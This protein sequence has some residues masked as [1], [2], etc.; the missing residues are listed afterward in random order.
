[1]RTIVATRV[2]Q[3]GPPRGS[4]N[5]EERLMVRFPRVW[6]AVA[7][8]GQRLFSPRSRLRRAFFRREMISAYAA[9]S[10]EDYELI[11]VRYAPGIEFRFA[12]EFG[13]LDVGGTSAGRDGMLKLINAF[14]EAWQ[15][16][17]FHPAMF[18][19]V[20]DRALALGH[21]RQ[22]G[23]ATGLEF[24]TE[25]A[26][27]LTLGRGAIAR[28]E[29]FLSWDKGMQAAGLDPDAIALPRAVRAA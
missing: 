2:E 8:V 16:V 20:G 27:L 11:M 9:A 15:Q 12:A 22:V 5:L 19:D 18:I 1:M 3:S 13:E 7:A 21:I 4:R 26:Q 24:V 28:E 10:R 17:E 29:E 25:F 6:R 14:Q 23:A